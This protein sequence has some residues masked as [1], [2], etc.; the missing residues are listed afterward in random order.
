[1]KI[2]YKLSIYYFS[3][4][5]VNLLSF[6][7]STNIN[8]TYVSLHKLLYAYSIELTDK[9]SALLFLILISILYSI[10]FYIS[11]ENILR[12]VIIVLS[13]LMSLPI[14]DLIGQGSNSF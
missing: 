6:S 12:W 13:F 10:I 2:Q 5:I 3:L 4:L 9:I 14:I 11:K 1:M 7:Y 8:N